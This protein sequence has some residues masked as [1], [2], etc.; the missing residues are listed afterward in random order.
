MRV[1]GRDCEDHVVP[2]PRIDL[3]DRAVQVNV[4]IQT[5]LHNLIFVCLR[6]LLIQWIFLGDMRRAFQEV[7]NSLYALDSGAHA[8]CR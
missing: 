8:P 6:V 4:T 5:V 7:A 1:G 3:S 2:L